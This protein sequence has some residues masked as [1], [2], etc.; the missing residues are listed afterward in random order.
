MKIN[1]LIFPDND[2]SI[3]QSINHFAHSKGMKHRRLNYT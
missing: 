1:R 2:R 3:N